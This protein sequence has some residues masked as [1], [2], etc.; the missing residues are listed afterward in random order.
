MDASIT[1][2]PMFCLFPSGAVGGSI[3]CRPLLAGVAAAPVVGVVPGPTDPDDL[4]AVERAQAEAAVN[5]ARVPVRVTPI[6]LGTARGLVID[7]APFASEK[8]LDR[9]FV[10]QQHAALGATV[11]LAA[12]PV[13]GELWLIASGTPEETAAFVGRVADRWL[14]AA[15]DQRL[16]TA[17]LSVV[18]GRV[19]GLFHHDPAPRRARAG[20]TGW[21]ARWLGR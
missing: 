8:L 12:V 14:D 17:V 3:A 19:A 20:R 1:S 10:D 5:L 9:A 18:R 15:P 11:L 6:D 16:S 21:L 4:A 2:A 7:G 13:K